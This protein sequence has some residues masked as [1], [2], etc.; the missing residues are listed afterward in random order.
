MSHDSN[1]TIWKVFNLINLA[2]ILYDN[3]T[4]NYILNQHAKTLLNINSDD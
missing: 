3:K 2:V 4:H 1:N